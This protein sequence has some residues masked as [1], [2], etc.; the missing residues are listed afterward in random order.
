[1]S[2]D[3]SSPKMDN[4]AAR[5]AAQQLVSPSQQKLERLIARAPQDREEMLQH[6]LAYAATDLLCYRAPEE[7]VIASASEAIHPGQRKKMDCFSGARNDD[8]RTQQAQHFDPILDWAQATYGI[9]LH[10][11]DSIMPVAQPE[12]SLVTIATLIGAA[13][14]RE[15]A[16]FS[17]LVPILGS[18]LLAL[19]V[20]KG[21]V[22]IDAALIAARLDEDVQAERYGEDTEMVQKWALKCADARAAAAML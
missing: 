7:S 16:A 15:L 3:M 19:A 14:D 17:L 5:H 1:M 6:L 8:L 4:G 11:T 10:V 18:V 20:W 12:A 2:M 13:N 21:R 9:T 22:T